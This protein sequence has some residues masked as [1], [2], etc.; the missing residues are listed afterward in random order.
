MIIEFIFSSLTALLH[1]YTIFLFF[2]FLRINLMHVNATG[3]WSCKSIEPN[4]K[5]NGSRLND[6]IDCGMQDIPWKKNSYNTIVSP[7]Q[8][9]FACD[10]MSFSSKNYIVRFKSL[11]VIAILINF[12]LI[13]FKILFFS[14]CVGIFFISSFVCYS[15]NQ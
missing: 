3:E 13:K 9:S 2:L 8:Y 10:Q 15:F 7:F 11:Q 14:N 6:S 1:L 4:G 12:T 5:Y